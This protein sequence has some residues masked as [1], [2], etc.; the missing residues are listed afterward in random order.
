M[1]ILILHS[2]RIFIYTEYELT[3]TVSSGRGLFECTL[4]LFKPWLG[5]GVGLPSF[6][7]KKGS[8]RTLRRRNQ[9]KQ[10]SFFFVCFA[11]ENVSALRRAQGVGAV[12]KGAVEVR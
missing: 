8:P 12:A 4:R 10:D 1:Q 2:G 5:G 7:S 6:L 11:G 3:V 9:I